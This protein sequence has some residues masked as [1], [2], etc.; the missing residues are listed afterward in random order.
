MG[1]SSGYIFIFRMPDVS[2]AVRRWSPS[3]RKLSIRWTSGQRSS[4]Q[5][6]VDAVHILARPAAGI[7]GADFDYQRWKTDDDVFCQ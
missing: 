1:T 4:F 7:V 3:A 6:A 5:P 2:R